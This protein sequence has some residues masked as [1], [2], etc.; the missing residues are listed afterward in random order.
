M[1][2]RL[3]PGRTFRNKKHHFRPRHSS[4]CPSSVLLS[5]PYILSLYTC[6][7]VKINA[8]C[9]SIPST[10]RVACHVVGKELNSASE[11]QHR[12]LESPPIVGAAVGIKNKSSLEVLE[13]KGTSEMSDP[14]CHL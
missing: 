11:V 10:Q 3:A 9:V 7:T 14:F 2:H 6:L 8:L 12:L 1:R 4:E 13:S 5:T